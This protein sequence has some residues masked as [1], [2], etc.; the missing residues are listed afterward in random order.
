MA[1]ENVIM[2]DV[3]G[4]IKYVDKFA[5]D[6]FL[7]NDIQ[8]VDAMQEIDSGRFILPIREEN[9]GELLG[10]AQLVS[11]ETMMDE[12]NFVKTVNKLNELYKGSLNLDMISLAKSENDLGKALGKAREFDGNLVVEYSEL[13]QVNDQIEALGKSKIAYSYLDE[14]DAKMSELDSLENF[15]YSLGSVTK[16]NAVRLK[17]I[18]NSVTSIVFHVGNQEDNEEVFMIVSPKDL[19]I[20][21]Q[22]IL[23]ALNFK[24]IEGFDGKYT[25]SPKEILEAIDAEI[26]ALQA[27]N[28]ELLKK[29]NIHLEENRADATDSFNT[30]SLYA[31]LSIIKKFMAFSDEN[32]Y[33]SGWISKRDKQRMEAIAAKYPEMIIMFSDTNKGSGKPPTKMKN[34]WLFKPFENLVKLYG[35]PSFNELD[36]TPFLSLTYMFCFG[37]MFGDVG[38]GLVLA[39][40]G[41][42][43]GKRGVELGKVLFRLGICSTFFGFMYG[44]VFG[45]E[46][47]IHAVWLRPFEEINSI[48]FVA[49]G[50]GIG[51]LFV[52]YVYSIINKLRQKEIK[53]GVFG[54]NGICGFV[55][56]ASLLAIV[57]VNAGGFAV[58]TV[59]TPILAILAVLLIFI[60]LIR[61]PLANYLQ[62]NS[63]LYEEEPSAYY[64]ESGF[65]LFEMLLGMFSNTV[66]FIR[67]GAFAL[68][69]VGLF[70]AFQTLAEMAHNGVIS[71]GVL[72]FANIFVIVLETLIVSIQALRLQFYELFSKYYTGDGV[73]FRP[74]DL[75]I[76]LF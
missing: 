47:V 9:M 8:I 29:L 17:S 40:A 73:E 20:E 32:F 22:R 52:A 36:P 69:H 19:E 41:F 49:I 64:I 58:A 5:K 51:M 61:E 23:K 60:V 30:L 55:L 18:Y 1:I 54:K 15:S 53:E 63:H 45:F 67:I 27:R 33:F 26:K 34:N 25:E 74:V 50:I 3:V 48:L 43:L 11:G 14:L 28:A 2:M 71:V 37:F 21:S 44:S 39:V 46:E 70:V 6:I 68:V 66:S 13:K 12:K 7:F 16:D 35:V 62:K 42:I 76:N 56:Y 65:E 57:G 72:I 31:N 59:L 38:Q 75:Q 24:P 10:F 4:K